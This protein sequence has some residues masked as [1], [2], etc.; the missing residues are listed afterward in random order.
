[1]GL[2]AAGAE[3]DANA[4][5]AQVLDAASEWGEGG[6]CGVDEREDHD[7]DA[8]GGGLGEDAQGVGVADALPPFADR[9]KWPGPTMIASAGRDLGSPGLR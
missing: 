8:E 4:F 5:A 7:R 9:V 1:M 6:E 3:H 2:D